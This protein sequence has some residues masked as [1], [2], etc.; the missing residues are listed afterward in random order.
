MPDI[1]IKNVPPDL[2]RALP[3]RAA[4]AG[5]TLSELIIERLTEDLARPS[6]DFRQWVN[7]PPLFDL[8]PG[9]ATAII[10]EARGE[11]PAVP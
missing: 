7:E 11:L 8:E 5:T 6:A 1:E 9:E 3:E 10:R 2:R 4:A